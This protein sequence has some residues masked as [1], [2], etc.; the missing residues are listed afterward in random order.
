MAAGGAASVGATSPEPLRLPGV[1]ALGAGPPGAAETVL[2]LHGWGGSKEL[3]WNTLT[4]LGGDIQGVALDLPGTGDTPLPG[5]VRTMPDMAQWVAGVC[6]R[7]ELPSVTLVGHSLGGNLAAQV[8]LDF[9]GL[10]RRLVL[11]DAALDPSSLPRNGRWPLSARFGLTAL[12]L[13]RLAAWPLAVAGRR[14][15]HAHSGGQWLPY[16]RRSHLYLSFNTDEAMQTQLRALYD[17]PHGAERLAALAIPLLI[18]HGRRDAIV[19]VA[20]ARALAEALPQSRL[21][22]FPGAQH[23]PDGHGPAAV[24]AAP[25]GLLD[26]RP[27]VCYNGGRTF[28]PSGDSMKTLVTLFLLVLATLPAGAAP[29]KTSADVVRMETTKGLILIKLFP[30]AAPITVKQFETLVNKGFYNG[31]TYHRVEDLE[32]PGL[33]HIVQGGDPNGDGTGGSGHTIKGEFPQN[34]VKNPLKHVAGTVSMARSSDPDSADSQFYIC[35]QPV[36]HLDGGYAA[37]GQVI[38][39]LDVAKKLVVGD[40]MTKVTMEPK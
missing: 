2:Y 26:D 38:K 20:H 3:W 29:K 12:R 25:A 13:S 24:R 27:A 16:A 39:G 1:G 37:F 21:V 11:V 18:M 7:L 35:T 31:L 36:P 23:W 19:P 6:A 32:G 30:K 17:N 14:I 5:D 10:A 34:G 22:I 9:P 40:K 28:T 15:P 4:A 33:G 8:A